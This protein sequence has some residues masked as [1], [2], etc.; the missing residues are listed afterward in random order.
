MTTDCNARTASRS[1]AARTLLLCACVAVTFLSFFYAPTIIRAQ[2]SSQ[3]NLSSLNPLQLKIEKERRRLASSDKE[4]RR[5]AVMRLGLMAHPESS[6]VAA[7]AL[8]D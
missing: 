2:E 8:N 4:E 1:F 5:D 7:S 6:R 3:A